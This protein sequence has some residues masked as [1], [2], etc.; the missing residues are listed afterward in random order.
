MTSK[1]LFVH[2]YIYMYVYIIIMIT[3]LIQKYCFNYY[4]NNNK[5]SYYILSI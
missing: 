1:L 2:I 4:I 3:W 5:I